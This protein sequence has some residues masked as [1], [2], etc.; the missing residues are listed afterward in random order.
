MISLLKSIWTVLKTTFRKRAT[1]QY[2]EERPYIPP[3]WRGQDH[4]FPRP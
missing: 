3:R 2:P 4:P 1:I